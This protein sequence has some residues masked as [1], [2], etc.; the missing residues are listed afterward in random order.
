[1]TTIFSQIDA[2]VMGYVHALQVR[3]CCLGQNYF[4][5]DSDSAAKNPEES[6][7]AIRQQNLF[8]S[9]LDLRHIKRR[10]R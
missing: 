10:L 4:P 1:M 2:I 7:G 9:P 8:P 3:I 5:N 6:E